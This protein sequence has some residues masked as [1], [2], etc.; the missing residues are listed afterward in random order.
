LTSPAV[1][2]RRTHTIAVDIPTPNRAAACR[3]E[4]PAPAASRAGSAFF[5]SM[6]V[7]G[8]GEF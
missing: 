3:A 8:L 1:R 2:A 4:T 5:E 6:G 7:F